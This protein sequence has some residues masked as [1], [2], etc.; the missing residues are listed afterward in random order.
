MRCHNSR[1]AQD[2]LS[3]SGRR[4]QSRPGG[5]DMAQICE[6]TAIVRTEFERLLDTFCEKY[7]NDALRDAAYELLGNLLAKRVLVPEELNVWA[8]GLIQLARDGLPSKQRRNISIVQVA[9]VFAANR[10][11]IRE[12]ASKIRNIIESESAESPEDAELFHNFTLRDEANAICAYAFRN[13]PIEDIHASVDSDGRDRITDAEMKQMM[14][15]ASKKL[16]ELLE[17]KEQSPEEYYRFIRDYN[18][19]WCASWER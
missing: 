18:E 19:H 4:V 3:S 5:F 16:S 1:L 12:R 17:M 7:P 13:G 2:I 11:I 8:G 9:E 14:T 6:N 15:T 10:Y